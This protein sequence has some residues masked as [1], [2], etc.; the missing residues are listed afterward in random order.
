MRYLRYWKVIKGITEILLKPTIKKTD[1]ESIAELMRRA[2]DV[3]RCL[4]LEIKKES[5]EYQII[6]AQPPFLQEHGIGSVD[7]IAGKGAL[8]RVLETKNVLLVADVKNNPLT[9]YMSHWAVIKNINAVL[10]MPIITDGE[11]G[12]IMV[13]DASGNRYSFTYDEVEFAGGCTEIIQN[14][15]DLLAREREV[16]L[17]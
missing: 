2:L 15:L 13:Y 9:A 4:I 3:N 10:F 1:I 5:N 17:V 11:V 6:S 14:L 16:E 8:E 12:L 7:S